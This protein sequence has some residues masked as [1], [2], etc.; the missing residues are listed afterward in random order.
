MQKEQ[1]KVSIESSRMFMNN[2]HLTFELSLHAKKTITSVT[3][4]SNRA[5][6]QT[7]G[8]SSISSKRRWGKGYATEIA[9]ALVRYGF[10]E[11][12]LKRVIATVD[13]DNKT[14]IRILEKVGMTLDAK[15]TDEQGEFLIYAINHL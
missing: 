3:P 2:L 10:E 6:A 14:S 12:K 4:K 7:T 9:R 13:D 1:M 5:K 11:R 8:K 15:E